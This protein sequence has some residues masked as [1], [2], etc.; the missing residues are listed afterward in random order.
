MYYHESIDTRGAYPDPLRPDQLCSSSF[1]SENQFLRMLRSMIVVVVNSIV[2]FIT[3]LAAAAAA[4]AATARAL[5]ASGALFA[6]RMNAMDVTTL[7]A[8]GAGTAVGCRLPAFESPGSANNT[9]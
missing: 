5:S 2:I 6:A 8:A 1:L 7:P 9:G 3:P 4:A